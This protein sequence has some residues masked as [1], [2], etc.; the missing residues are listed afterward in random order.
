M[1]PKV[2]ALLQR[3]QW[4]QRTP[5]WYERRLTLMT[6]SDAAGAL[7]IKAF[8][9]QKGDVRAALLQQKCSSSFK[10][11]MYTQHGQDNEDWVR[12]R[13]ADILND[14]ALE[15]GLLVHKDLDWLGA[16]PDGIFARSGY[17]I[18]I[19]CPYRRRIVPGHVPHHYYPQIQCQLEVCSLPACYFVQWQ[20]AHLSHTGEEIF[21]V[22]CVER[23]PKWFAQHKDALHAFWK[24]LMEARASY[25]K[26][27]SPL[28][29][30]RDDLYVTRPAEDPQEVDDCSSPQ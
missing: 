10:G 25:V 9:S 21:D 4:A 28:T 2:A 18:E 23:D 16:S 6:A 22:V 27:P 13:L 14:E 8:E 24:D 30:I 20:P 1:H 11:N 19:K 15:F 12:D 5:E 17:M 29:R 26:P 3:P 7:G